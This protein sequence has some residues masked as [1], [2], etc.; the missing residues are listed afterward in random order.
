MTWTVTTDRDGKRAYVL[1]DGTYVQKDGAG[2]M[3][4]TVYY[5]DHH[6]PESWAGSY[7]MTD[8]LAEA[9]AWGEMP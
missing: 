6:H 9:K 7:G 3:K 5:R 8:T 1:P 4:W 2:R